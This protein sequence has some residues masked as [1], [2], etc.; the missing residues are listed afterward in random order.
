MTLVEATERNAFT[1]DGVFFSEPIVILAPMNHISPTSAKSI[2]TNTITEVGKEFNV[3]GPEA[4]DPVSRRH[5]RNIV[6]HVVTEQ[7]LG[8]TV[9]DNIPSHVN[10]DINDAITTAVPTDTQIG[11]GISGSANKYV[12]NP[13]TV[14]HVSR[15][16]IQTVFDQLSNN[17]THLTVENP[18]KPHDTWNEVQ[19]DLSTTQSAELKTHITYA[20]TLDSPYFEQQVLMQIP[21]NSPLS[22]EEATTATENIFDH[23][24]GEVEL[25]SNNQIKPVRTTEFITILQTVIN[26]EL[27]DA[28]KTTNTQTKKKFGLAMNNVIPSET[29]REQL[30]DQIYSPGIIIHITR[31]TIQAMFE[32]MSD[33]ET[34]LQVDNPFNVTGHKWNETK[35]DE[36]TNLDNTQQDTSMYEEFTFNKASTDDTVSLST[37]KTTEFTIS[38]ITTGTDLPVSGG[39]NFKAD[40]YAFIKP[41]SNNVSSRYI[42][43]N[44]IGDLSIWRTGKHGGAKKNT[45]ESNV[46]IQIKQ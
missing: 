43:K 28:S 25:T 35:T 23:V 27:V 29:A 3:F 4:Y 46:D 22:K 16:I 8:N 2:A 10:E 33:C 40:A 5:V 44:K 36:I 26:R 11:N 38:N 19:T 15:L 6:E 9:T 24:A 13:G 17:Q 42:V 14:I 39:N 45:A 18:F 34:H 12:N 32:E 41:D 30:P 1:L 7:C 37:I 21:Q 31:M 20:M